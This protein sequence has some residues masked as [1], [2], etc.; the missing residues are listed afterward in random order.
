M[1]KFDRKKHWETI[2]QTKQLN[3]VSWLQTIPET[4]LDFFRELEVAVQAHRLVTWD[5]G[6]QLKEFLKLLVQKGSV[7]Q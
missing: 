2:Y 4:S 1:G 3:E 6:S 5:K 7:L